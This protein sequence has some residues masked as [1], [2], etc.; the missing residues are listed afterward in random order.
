MK[1]SPLNARLTKMLTTLAAI[2]SGAGLLAGSATAAHTTFKSGTY[3]GKT[4]QGAPFAV[5]LLKTS[6][7][8]R[9]RALCLF[10]KTQPEIKTTCPNGESDEYEDLDYVV[11][12]ASGSIKSKLKSGDGAT[13]AAAFQIHKNGTITGSFKITGEPDSIDPEEV[14]GYC[15][16]STTFTLKR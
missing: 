5:K 16:G 11:V 9:G 4:S 8:D 1:E 10:T 3:S 15:S 6:E 2:A 13:N 12:P 7:C 14:T